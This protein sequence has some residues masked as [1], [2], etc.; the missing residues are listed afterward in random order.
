MNRVTLNIS[1]ECYNTKLN[2][3]FHKK[4]TKKMTWS[5]F[6]LYL[7][8][9]HHNYINKSHS[10]YSIC[11]KREKRILKRMSKWLS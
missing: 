11:G 8:T 5:Y 9:T 1:Y 4:N 10:D 7:H 2:V 3:E 6:I